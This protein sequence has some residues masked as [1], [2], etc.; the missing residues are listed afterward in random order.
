MAYAYFLERWWQVRDVDVEV[1]GCQDRSLRNAD[2]E[3]SQ[4]APFA[5]ACGKG[6]VAITNQLHDQAD[7]APVR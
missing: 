1:K 6:E 7:H 2:L 3:A 4:P 5:V